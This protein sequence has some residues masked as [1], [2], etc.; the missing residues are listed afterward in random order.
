MPAP[1]ANPFGHPSEYAY[2]LEFNGSSLLETI[3]N[4]SEGLIG[5]HSFTPTNA[6]LRWWHSQPGQYQARQTCRFPTL[7][8][9]LPIPEEAHLDPT[10]EEVTALR[11]QTLELLARY[12]GPDIHPIGHMAVI[13][14]DTTLLLDTVTARNDF[15]TNRTLERFTRHCMALHD[16]AEVEYPGIQLVFGE[17]VGDIPA[18][19]KTKEN[20]TL[21]KKILKKLLE[22]V[23]NSFYLEPM[24]QG[25]VNFI[26][27]D[28]EKLDD[29]TRAYHTVGEVAH[30]LRSRETGM[31]IIGLAEEA[32]GDLPLWLSR[33]LLDMAREIEG[34]TTQSLKHHL[35]EVPI[36]KDHVT[37]RAA[38]L[39]FLVQNTRVN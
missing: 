12:T 5:D 23:F 39:A 29:T 4:P 7:H 35:K 22:E 9:D 26:R 33:A 17:A 6:L 30:D 11:K 14:S 10:S 13:L 3:G 19:Q 1:S 34:N 20:K 2:P 27:H 8:R 15:P 21:E 36:L 18:G 28:T 37:T 24:R 38:D 25:M 31:Q 16:I 32:Y